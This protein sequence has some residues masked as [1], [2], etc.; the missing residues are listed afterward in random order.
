M[1]HETHETLPAYCIRIKG[2]RQSET[3]ALKCMLSGE[4]FGLKI[5]PFDASTPETLDADSRGILDWDLGDFSQSERY[6]RDG[7]VQACFLSH[8]LLWKL[9]INSG[10]P[11]IL[12]LEHDAVITAPI[13]VPPKKGYKVC[14]FGRPSFGK[15]QTPGDGKPD[16]GKDR[17][18]YPAFSKNQGAYLGGAHAYAVSP[19]GAEALVREA[20]TTGFCAT[21]IFLSRNRFPWLLEYWP[22]PVKV[23]EYFTT[24]QKRE[25][26]EA[27]HQ[28][29]PDGSYLVL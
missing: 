2:L 29:K 17:G 22:W 21:D 3:S 19:E 11:R 7:R 24:V 26:C 16:E 13:P 14:S 5:K 20:T 18:Y 1:K 23:D 8:F 25:G 27:K 9:A 28:F 12:I 15:F 6:S 10:A 4:R